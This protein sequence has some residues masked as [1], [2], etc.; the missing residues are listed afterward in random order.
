M[1]QRKSLAQALQTADLPPEALAVIKEGAVRPVEA[2]RPV[3]APEPEPERRPPAITQPPQRLPSPIEVEVPDEAVKRGLVPLSVRV[4]ADLSDFLL[5][6][7]FERKLQRRQPYSQQDIVTQAVLQWLK[8]N[9][10]AF[11]EK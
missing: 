4:N 1:N 6:V 11:G 8:R 5:R 2:R 3:L 10:Y 9:G 7:S